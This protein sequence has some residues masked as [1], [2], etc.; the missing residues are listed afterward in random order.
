MQHMKMNE[1]TLCLEPNFILNPF[2]RFRREV[3]EFLGDKKINK[4]QGGCHSAHIPTSIGE[5]SIGVLTLF[6]SSRYRLNVGY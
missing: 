3:H 4:L 1:L 6:V 2:D 5:G